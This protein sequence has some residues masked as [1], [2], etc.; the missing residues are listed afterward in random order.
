MTQLQL[1][2]P[3]KINLF[4]HIIGRRKDGYHNL[5]SVF[6]A[7]DFGDY[8]TFCCSSNT[9]IAHDD[10][11]IQLSGGEHL[12]PSIQDNL[13]FKAAQALY[14]RYPS[15]ACKVQITLDKHIPTGAGLGGGSSNCAT[16]LIAIN[17]LWQLNLSCDELISIGKTLGADVAFFIFSYFH[18]ADALAEGIG[19]KLH[20][21]KLPKTKYLLLFPDEHISTA[22]FF[23]HSQLQKNHPTYHDI[24]H[25]TQEYCHQLSPNF[26][27][28]FEPLALQFSQN[29]ANA[30][31]F[32]K[33]LEKYTD[34]TSRMSGTGSTVFLPLPP[35]LDT[36][37]LNSWQQ[38]A[39]CSSV[40]V[41]SIY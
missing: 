3:A 40:I 20:H 32:L 22:D 18:R 28:V 27:N 12:T 25:R 39:P 9:P 35:T 29:I 23:G 15:H 26:C 24:L 14:Q 34:T 36:D 1:F 5:Q 17:Q 11:L 21:L 37:M 31:N 10:D 2:S 8:M 16:T 4:L 38:S 41:Y 6:R 7:I 13:I 19:D 30:F 33:S